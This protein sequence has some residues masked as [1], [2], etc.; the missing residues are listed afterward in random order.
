MIKY[1]IAKPDL[2]GNELKYLTE[3]IETG[4]ISSKGPFIQR[5]EEK[6]AEYIGVKYSVACSSGTTALTLALASLGIKRGDEVI[7]PDFTM[8]ATA[9]PV[10]YLGAT[11]VFVDC[12]NDLNV[13]VSLIEAAITEKTKAIMPVHIYGRPANMKAI[14]KLA[15]DYNLFVIE[16]CAEAHGAIID[17]KMV[18][19]WGD[20]GCFSLFANKII[21]AGEGGLVTT[22][23]KR[24]YEQLTHLRSMAFDPEHTFLHKK[25]AY[26]FR[27]TN[28]QAAVGLAQLERID[29]FL[30]KRRQIQ[31]WYENIID[32]RDDMLIVR[33]EGSVLWVFDV[34]AKDSQEK[35]LLMEK[36]KKNGT[37]TR[38]F[39]KPMTVQPMYKNSVR[40]FSYS[41]PNYSE[42]GFYLPVYTSLTENDVHDICSVL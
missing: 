29:E 33:P 14:T 36:F 16:D 38:H 20:M 30:D 26:N 5:L 8:I 42:R 32:H 40:R 39:F 17:G 18:G 15:H 24:L 4:W 35:R 22:N 3:A 19:A 41:A 31:K 1:P 9:W 2:S 13:D 21:S 7:V 34:L 37:E 23:D 25:I 6:F 11:P 10:N 12:G 27:M 28:L